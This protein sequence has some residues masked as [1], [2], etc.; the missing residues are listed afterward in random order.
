MGRTWRYAKSSVNVDL[1][2]ENS[3]VHKSEPVVEALIL[4]QV[5]GSGVAV[6]GPDDTPLLGGECVVWQVNQLSG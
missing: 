5:S 3:T 1:V 4:E 2:G 6:E